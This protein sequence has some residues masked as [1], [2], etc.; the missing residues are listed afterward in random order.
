MPLDK[1]IQKLVR[2]SVAHTRRK[3]LA[4]KTSLPLEVFEDFLSPL[5]PGDAEG[6]KRDSNDRLIPT[7]TTSSVRHYKYLIKKGSV[8]DRLFQLQTL[9]AEPKQPSRA[10][11]QV[12]QIGENSVYEVDSIVGSRQQGKRKQYRVRWLGYTQEHDTWEY[13]SNINPDLVAAFEGGPPPQR[14]HVPVL[15][16][17]GAG[18]ARAR[19]SMAEQRRGGVPQSMSMV[20]GNVIIHLKESVKQT[21]MPSLR[22]IFY[23]LTMDKKGHII[24][25]TE[26]STTTQAA[27]RLQA[28]T[29]LK[30]MMDDPLNPVDATMAPALTGN[31]TSSVWQG[32]P[33]RTEVAA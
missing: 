24:W 10:P 15:P 26:F 3:E 6:L 19:L 4:I 28:R 23:V 32:A 27:L 13:K 12:E 22:I 1:A 20:C 18:A 16:H 30:K 33:R 29:L 31:G 2:P 14:A 8:S 5:A 7:S 21:H 25:P 11:A 17:R 9:D